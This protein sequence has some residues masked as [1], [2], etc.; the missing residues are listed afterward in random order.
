MISREK[1]LTQMSQGISDI[2]GV[3]EGDLTQ[4]IAKTSFRNVY[5]NVIMP[6]I[7][8]FEYDGRPIYRELL[9][10]QVRDLIA[11]PEPIR[12]IEDGEKKSFEVSD[13]I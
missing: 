1:L 4:R 2:L 5:L 13:D 12:V 9:I 11:E 10:A 8:G 7:D 3:P 6:L